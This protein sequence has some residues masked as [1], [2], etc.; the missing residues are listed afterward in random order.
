MWKKIEVISKFHDPKLIIVQILLYFRLKN[1]FVKIQ[2]YFKF[3]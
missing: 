2:S 3:I 1:I